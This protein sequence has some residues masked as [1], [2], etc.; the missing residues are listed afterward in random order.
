[1]RGG[2]IYILASVRNGTLYIGV[3]SDLAARV[4]KHRNEPEGFVRRYG[5]KLLV[6][7]E[8][9]PTVE[10]AIAREKQ[11]K[12]WNRSWKLELIEETNPDWEDLFEHIVG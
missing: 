8:E 11:I 9:Y 3:T 12:K 7:V 1:M 10:E 6:H 4:W 2:W 5:L